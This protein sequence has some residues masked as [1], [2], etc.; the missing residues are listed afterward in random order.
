M[1]IFTLSCLPG[2]WCLCMALAMWVLCFDWLGWVSAEICALSFAS[3]SQPARPSLGEGS[4]P[5][6][7]WMFFLLFE[8]AALVM[9]GDFQMFLLS[10]LNIQQK[11]EDLV[12]S[13]QAAW[14]WVCRGESVLPAWGTACCKREA[15]ACA[16]S[17]PLRHLL[18]KAKRE[19]CPDTIWE[20]TERNKSD[21]RGSEQEIECKASSFG[22][23]FIFSCHNTSSNVAVSMRGHLPHICQTPEWL[24]RVSPPSADVTVLLCLSQPLCTLFVKWLQNTGQRQ[25]Q[26]TAAVISHWWLHEV[27]STREPGP[28]AIWALSSMSQKAWPCL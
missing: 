26:F 12:R 21:S 22:S 9:W 3:R 10:I 1:K 7:S 18:E 14:H 24:C 5:L 13:H 4:L 16:S 11:S 27:Q 20:V 6:Y 28:K 17:S 23:E 8:C 19:F 15:A 2:S 25:L